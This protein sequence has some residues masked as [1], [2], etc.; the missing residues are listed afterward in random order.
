MIS[1]RCP[2]CRSDRV[3]LG[4]RPTPLWSAIVCRF[5]LLCDNCNWEFA[6]FAVPGTT[7]G[8]KKKNPRK[9]EAAEE[10]NVAEA[11]APDSAADSAGDSKKEKSRAK[12][13]R[14]AMLF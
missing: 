14:A 8:K 9:T 5:N 1:Q 2:R 3:R 6:G 11:A 13:S 10:N 4:Y 12:S 7:S